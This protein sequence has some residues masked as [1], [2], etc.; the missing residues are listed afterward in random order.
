MLSLNNINPDEGSR[1]KSKR[2]WRWNASWKWTFCGR[3]SN[4]QCSR[5]GWWMGP[6][7]EWWQTPLFRRLPKTKWFSNHMFKTEF[8]VVNLDD[9]E[10]L[11]SKW[12][13]EINKEILL[14]NW[15]IRKKS[16]WVKLL[17]KWELKSKVTITLDKVSESAKVA[18][19]KV[20]GTIEIITK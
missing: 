5:S 12:I 20:G 11:A 13:I 6:W 2:V 8:N 17:W 4:W 9:L 3:W 14:A 1:K 7:F 10:N 16:F 18:M 19:D 15:V